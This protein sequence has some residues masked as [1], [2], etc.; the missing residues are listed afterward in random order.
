MLLFGHHIN[1]LTE[2]HHSLIKLFDVWPAVDDVYI[3]LCLIM[4]YNNAYH[5]HCHYLLPL[6]VLHL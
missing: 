2:L 6:A 4:I 5:C 1:Q 3:A